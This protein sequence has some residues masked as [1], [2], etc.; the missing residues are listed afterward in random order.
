M[1]PAT[2]TLSHLAQHHPRWLDAGIR[3]DRVPAP[4]WL[5]AQ[6]LALWPAWLWMG[7]RLADGSDD[8]LGLLALAALAALAWQQRAAL[9]TA[10]RLGWLLL[11]GAATVAATLLRTGLGPLPAWPPLL[12]SLLAVLAIACGLLAFLPRPALGAAADAPLPGV[13]ALPVLGLAVLALPLLSSLQFYAGYPLRV[14]TAELSHWLLM[15]FFRVAREGASLWI[16]GRLVIVDAPCSGVQMVWLG[17]FT[18]CA[19]ALFFAH[20][21][22]R[23]F[24]TR[25]P[26]VSAL[27]LVGNVVRNALLV[28]AEG[29]GRALPGWAHEAL[30]L[31]V[32]AAVCGGIAFFMARPARTARHASNRKSG[33]GL[34][35]WPPRRAHFATDAA[36][37][38]SSLITTPGAR[39]VDTH[40]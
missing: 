16:S 4:F 12:A 28:A 34:I 6:A 26:V 8:P 20:S 27:V 18:A 24:L 5:A 9:R 22:S 14:L 30:G 13:P 1:R 11:A 19:T 38:P 10:P 23:T 15:P 3:L 37:P 32:L 39:R 7:R 2:L 36:T 33:S 40:A 21:D 35:A 31:A 29:A 17:Y 25:L